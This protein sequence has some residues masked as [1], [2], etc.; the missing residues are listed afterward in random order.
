M[1][2]KQQAVAKVSAVV[3][4]LSLGKQDTQNDVNTLVIWKNKNGQ[5]GGWDGHTKGNN[6]LDHLVPIIW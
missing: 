6:G 2:N 4:Q 3:G 5:D 1:P